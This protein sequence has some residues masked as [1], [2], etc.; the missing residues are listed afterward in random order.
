MCAWEQHDM[1]QLCANPLATHLWP[2]SR[3]LAT[4]AATGAAVS[5]AAAEHTLRDL[6]AEREQAQGPAQRQPAPM[7]H[8]TGR[9]TEGTA[10]LALAVRPAA[11]VREVE[12]I[13]AADM[14]LM[15]WIGVAA[16]RSPG[17]VLVR[18]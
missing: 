1:Q 15:S 6:A 12:R 13:M 2:R 5:T 18:R 10:G 3:S 16:W 11:L 9:G 4:G 14:V 8:R 7:E 17:L